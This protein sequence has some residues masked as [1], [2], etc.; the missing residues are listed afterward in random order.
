[1]SGAQYV[2]RNRGNMDRKQEGEKCSLKC[3]LGQMKSL[4]KKITT[5]KQI[6]QIYFRLMVLKIHVLN[7]IEKIN[8]KLIFLSCS[9]KFICI[10]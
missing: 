6:Y 10:S 2:L 9:L 4:G 7:F 5:S 1:M 8:F 3:R